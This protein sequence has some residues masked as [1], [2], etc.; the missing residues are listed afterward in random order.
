MRS[1]MI[2]NLIAVLS[3]CPVFC[4][5]EEGGHGTHWHGTAGSASSDA[6]SAPGH[7]PE[8]GESCICQGAIQSAAIRVSDSTDLSPVSFVIFDTATAAHPPAH[9]HL[10]WDGMPTGLA[11]WG[12]SLAVRAFLQNFRC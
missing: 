2:V 6:P 5:S 8:D 4:G 10:T 11:G 1:L 7:C 3:L 9:L 12:T